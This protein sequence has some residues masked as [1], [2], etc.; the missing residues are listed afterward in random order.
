MNSRAEYISQLLLTYQT[1]VKLKFEWENNRG[2][3]F[4]NGAPDPKFFLDLLK[5][6]TLLAQTELTKLLGDL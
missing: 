1:M 4:D 5:S 3:T 6:E 2:N